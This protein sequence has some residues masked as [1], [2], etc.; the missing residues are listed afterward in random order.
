MDVTEA[1]FQEEVIERSR[2]LPVIVDFW[3][4][5]CRPCR[6]LAPILD[7]AVARREGEVLLAK[8]DI[9]AN[10]ALARQYQIQSIPAVKGF[11]S[12]VVVAEFLG[13]QAPPAVEAFVERLVPSKADRLVALGDEASLREAIEGDPAH[14]G[15]RVALGRLLFAEGRAGEVEEVVAPVRHDRRAEGLLA[16]ASL[17]AVDNPDVAA[18]LAALERADPEAGLTHLLDALRA[19]PRDQ[20]EL[21]DRLRETMVGVFGELGDQH[22]LT[23]RFRRRLAQ[24]LY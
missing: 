18:G 2:E 6:Q 12:G 22:P 10:P 23:S 19:A 16:R 7:A 24:A 21:R 8:V 17:A 9:D 5:W 20:A 4:G 11:R 14:V 15:A 13:M 1:T 3:A